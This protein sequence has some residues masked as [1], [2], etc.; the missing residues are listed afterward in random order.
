MTSS[1]DGGRGGFLTISTTSSITSRSNSPLNEPE[2]SISCIR[3]ESR[4]VGRIA[5]RVESDLD[6]IPCPEEPLSTSILSGRNSIPRFENSVC[7]A[8]SPVR[9]ISSPR[10]PSLSLK[11]SHWYLESHLGSIY[12]IPRGGDRVPHVPE[13][14]LHANPPSL[15]APS[16][17]GRHCLCLSASSFQRRTSVRWSESEEKQTTYGS[18]GTYRGRPLEHHP[19]VNFV[20]F[21]LSRPSGLVVKY[22]SHVVGAESVEANQDGG[23]SPPYR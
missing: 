13:R 8:L 17:S 15:S 16:L 4:P 14:P 5:G 20:P 11:T 7:P 18:P 12:L 22:P 6:A 9:G 23:C 19:W 2:S 21:L 10:A 3:R 1:F